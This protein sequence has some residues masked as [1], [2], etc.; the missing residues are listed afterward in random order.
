MAEKEQG[1]ITLR[2]IQHGT[3]DYLKSLDLREEVL[4]K[5]LGMRLEREELK[6]EDAGLLTAWDGEECVGTMVLSEEDPQS[7]RMKA[8]AVRHDYQKRGIGKQMTVEFE[9]E[10]ARRC[11]S[12]VYLHARVVAVEFYLKQGYEVFGEEFE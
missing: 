8:V 6:E 5:P 1:P 12:R 10:S 9:E 4:R 3:P 2:W 7:A 11:Y